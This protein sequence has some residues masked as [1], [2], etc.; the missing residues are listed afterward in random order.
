MVLPAWEMCLYGLLAVGS[1]LYA[2][3]EAHQVSQKYEA[4]MDRRFGLEPGTLFRGLKKDPMDFEWSYWIE[5]GRE[6]ILWLLAGHLLVSQVSRLL[7]EKYKPWC[8][9]V[10]GMAACWLLLGIKGFAVILLHATIS[11]AVAQFQL[12]LLTWLCSLILL[13]TLRIPAVEEAKR[14][15]Y[16]TE[17][18]Y[19]LLLFTVS[20][21]CLFC[22]SFSLEYCWHGPAQKSS[23]SFLWMLAYV[24]YYPTFHNGPLMNFDDFS[25]QMRRKEAFSLK[26]NL[27]ILILGIIRIF[28]WWCLAELMIHLMYIHALYSSAPPLEAASY[29]ALGGLALAQVLF[30]YVKYLVLYGVPALLLQ[31]DGLKPP[32][33]P[34]CVSLMH[35]F[36]KMWRSFD[37][38]LHRFLVRYIYVPMGGSQSS[39]LGTLFSTAL[40]FAFVSYW[41]GGQSYLWY[42][43]ALNWL[44]VIVENGVKRILSISL[45]Q[46]LI[47]KALLPLVILLLGDLPHG[48]EPDKHPK[49]Y[50][51][52]DKSQGKEGEELS[53]LE[54]PPL[55]MYIS[56]TGIVYFLF[57]FGDIRQFSGAQAIMQFEKQ[58]SFFS[59][60]IRR[61]LHAVLASVSTSM[62]ILSN[63]IFLGGNHVGKIYWNRIFMEGKFIFMCFL[64]FYLTYFMETE[65][66]WTSSQLSSAISDYVSQDILDI[67]LQVGIS[68]IQG[69]RFRGLSEPKSLA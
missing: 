67:D 31:M 40:T 13:S 28:F 56:S 63:L 35:S 44:G 12:S 34:C 20:V 68:M 4:V 22:T 49:Q 57:C 59:P 62:L 65:S 29:W 52:R 60:R 16:D 25:K 39:L 7:V 42:W 61:R 38:G 41:H 37:V 64:G 69:A 21:R 66:L 15:W 27:S 1:H 48:E 36:T 9:M 32:A 47:Q 53:Y 17:N 33:L 3:Y 46:D 19:Y 11:F 30:F 8:L 18:E 50:N 24:F 26:T 45:I 14:K 10:Y 58:E 6:R 54:S 43:G 2:F 55:Q 51:V 23:H 5:W